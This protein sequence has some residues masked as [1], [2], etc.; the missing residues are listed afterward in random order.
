[1]LIFFCQVDVN[2][3]K[4]CKHWSTHLTYNI[5]LAISLIVPR[6]GRSEIALLQHADQS[7]ISMANIRPKSIS[8]TVL[9]FLWLWHTHG[10]NE[11]LCENIQ[12]SDSANLI[13]TLTWFCI[14]KVL[15][16]WEIWEKVA[17]TKWCKGLVPQGALFYVLR[18]TAEH[19]LLS[20]SKVYFT[21]R[22]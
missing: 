3:C 2:L 20:P 4:L 17:C 1:M 8:Q 10:Y 18:I 6:A 14:P 11:C 19:I 16:Y 9:L 21:R 7:Q 5:F 15:F 22:I 13:S 12:G